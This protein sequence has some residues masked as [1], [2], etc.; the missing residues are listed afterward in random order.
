MS[1]KPITDSSGWFTRCPGILEPL[2]IFS[3]ISRLDKDQ[4]SHIKG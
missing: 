1:S 2:R 3:N 4:E